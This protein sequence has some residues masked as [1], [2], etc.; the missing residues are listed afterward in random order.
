[1]C[2]TTEVNGSTVQNEERNRA[3]SDARYT[4]A[5]ASS[6]G[7]NSSRAFAH[8]WRQKNPV[9]RSRAALV[10]RPGFVRSAARTDR[11]Q[12]FICV[13]ACCHWL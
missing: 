10:G 9:N 7:P 13:H 12:P 2:W 4:A 6:G 8:R 3:T 5:K 11:A 1:M